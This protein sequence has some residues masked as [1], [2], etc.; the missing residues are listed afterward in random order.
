MDSATPSGAETGPEPDAYTDARTDAVRRQLARLATDDDTAP[1]V[2]PDVTARIGAALRAAPRPAAAHAHT[3]ERPA[4]SAAQRAAVLAGLVATV[5]AVIVGVLI[6]ARDPGPSFA[7]GPTASQITVPGQP[8]FP[9]ADAELRD[10]LSAEP[11]LGPLADR[12]RLAS[13]LTG[14]DHSPTET[15]LG[16]RYLERGGRPAVVLLLPGST[17]QQISAVLVEPT[18]SSVDTGLLARTGLQRR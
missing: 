8:P 15:V 2:P 7:P 4:M 14:L 9:L 10:M 18:C 3:V 1:D 16:G 11:D 13:C 17:P 6:L 5:A 12:Q